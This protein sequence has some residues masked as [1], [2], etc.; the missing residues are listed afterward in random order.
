VLS[1]RD[2]G[3][4][5]LAE[6]G[7]VRCHGDEKGTAPDARRGPNLANVG[8]RVHTDYLERFLADP[9][10]ADPGTTMPGLLFDR[11]TAARQEAASALSAYLRSLANAPTAEAASSDPDAAARGKTLFHQVGC[12]ACHAPRDDQD[13]EIALPDSVPI[14]NV[15]AKY[16][17]TA[18]RAFLLAPHDAR[19]DSRMPD[20]HLSPTE[21]HEL[22]SYLLVGAKPSAPAPAPDAA[23]IEN[24][25]TL[26]AQRGCAACHDLPDSNRAAPRTYKPLRELKNLRGGCMST[27]YGAWPA[28]E[29]SDAQ[30]SDLTAAMQS[31]DAATS[32][33]QRIHQL[34]ASRHCTACHARGQS[35]GVPDDRSSYFT[36]RDPSMG[37]EA[38]IPPP[39]TGIGAKLQPKWLR[40]A[41]AHG[42]AIRPYLHTRMPGFGDTIAA[43]LSPLLERTDTLPPLSLPPFPDDDKKRHEIRDLGCELVGDKGMNCIS[44]HAFAGDKVGMMAAVDLIDSTGER[45]R[46][47]W[48]HHFLRAPY[49]FKQGTLMPQFFVGGVSSRPNLG[50]GDVMQ[51]IDGIWQYLAEG[52]NTRQPS[53]MRHPA[54]EL[55]VDAEAVLL[56]RSAQRTGKRGISV[57]YPGG[58]SLTFDAETLGLNQIWWG[59]FANASGVFYGQ[60]SGEVHP[61]SQ[62]LVELP[63][64][65]AFVQLSTPEAPWP[66]ATRRELGHEWLGYDLDAQ[67]R[68]TFRYRCEGVTITDTPSEVLVDKDRPTLRRTLTFAS[69]KDPTLHFRAARSTRIEELGSDLGTS[70]IAVGPSLRMRLPSGSFRIR[71]AAQERELLVAIPLQQG[72]AQLV[73]DYR[74]Q[75][76]K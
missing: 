59:K 29:L 31:L 72:K 2:R 22:A 6:L 50:G 36:T 3:M 65:P 41:I 55:K 43:A 11:S 17:S 19:P 9:H 37:M 48:F 67:Q 13:R 40:D 33:E 66:T 24:G 14:G 28:F 58:V 61:M 7:C 52:R 25:R 38:R 4:V 21:A 10:A 5:L 30:R 35:G 47:E 57:G 70:D 26:F 56:R 34:L 73:I 32:D 53:G 60:G 44:C 75:E 76:G 68:P 69:E 45:L 12:A 63:K 64:G 51:Q 62:Q 20:L 46:R 23:K 74:Y 49:E 42:Q 18:L 15:A 27:S 8:N 71:A 16:Q 39:L 1:A 54:I